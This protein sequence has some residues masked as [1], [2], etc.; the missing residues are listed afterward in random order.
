[1]FAIQPSKKLKQVCRA[2]GLILFIKRDPVRYFLL[3]LSHFNMLVSTEDEHIASS[4]QARTALIFPSVRF[5][6]L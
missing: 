6:A 2:S 4:N 3:G 1:M 5:Q